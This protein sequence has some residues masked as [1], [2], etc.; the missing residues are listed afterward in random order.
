MI[1][2]IQPLTP[3]EVFNKQASKPFKILGDDFNN[4]YVKY[5]LED[6]AEYQFLIYEVVCH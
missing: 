3:Q 1:P 5:I 2:V 6:T 4:Y